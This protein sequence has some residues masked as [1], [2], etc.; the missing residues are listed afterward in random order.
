[1]DQ[2]ASPISA[3]TASSLISQDIASTIKNPRQQQTGS[4]ALNN[5]ISDTLET[6]D[7][8]SEGTSAWEIPEEKTKS[9]NRAVT[10]T[11]D[12]LDLKG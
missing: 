2:T 3:S 12:F 5:Q 7:R 6:Q 9:D 8:E 10:T 11:G 4:L 1:M